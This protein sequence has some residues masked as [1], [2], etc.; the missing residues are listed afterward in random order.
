M[1]QG[2]GVPLDPT[3]VA[4]VYKRTGKIYKTAEE[5]HTT[6]RRIAKILDELGVERVRKKGSAGT[7][8]QTIKEKVVAAY[9][10]Y[11]AI[12]RVAEELHISKF[13]ISEML[14]DA[15]VLERKAKTTDRS[16]QSYDDIDRW[17]RLIPGNKVLTP[18]GSRVIAA[19]YPYHVAVRTRYG[20]IECFTKGNLLVCATNKAEGR[21]YRE[22]EEKDE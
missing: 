18:K 1:S 21:D 22:R 11:G 7:G 3:E 2:K 14:K 6:E 10:K 20:H 16:K 17:L 4:E 5:L 8:T 12:S 13:R 9:G 15:G 19:V